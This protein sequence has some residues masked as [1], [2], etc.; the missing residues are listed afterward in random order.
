VVPG[1]IRCGHVKG[2]H[3][4]GFESEAD[5]LVIKH[6]A[7]SRRGFA[8]GALL[9]AELSAKFPG[10]WNFQELLHKHRG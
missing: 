4:V 3:E 10:I 5:R 1:S 6:E 9:A 7:Y 8:K 2:V